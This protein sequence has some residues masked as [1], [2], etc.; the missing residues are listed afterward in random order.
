MKGIKNVA[1]ILLIAALALA[2]AL[3]SACSASP[4]S[5]QP[6]LGT[7]SV[8]SG[9]DTPQGGAKIALLTL[10][11]YM[12]QPIGQE[13]WDA[14]TRFAGE[15]GITKGLYKTEENEAAPTLDLAVKGGAKLVIVLGQE[16][17]ALMEQAQR[18][19]PDVYFV[20][21][22]ADENVDLYS[23]GLGVRF[24][25]EQAGWLA[26][27]A[28][29]CNGLHTM[30][31]FESEDLTDQRYALGFLL[32][33][34]AAVN[35]GNAPGALA[36]FP[37]N[38]PGEATL[39]WQERLTQLLH[40]GVQ[41]VFANVPTAQVEILALAQEYDVPVIVTDGGGADDIAALTTTTK[42][43]YAVLLLVLE[44]WKLNNLPW[45]ELRV[46]GIAG[47]AIALEIPAE[48][49]NFTQA[50]YETAIER[51]TDDKVEELMENLLQPDE[52]G[53]LPS[54]QSLGLQ[55]VWVSG[56]FSYTSPASSSSQEQAPPPES[57]APPQDA[58]PDVQSTPPSSIDQSSSATES[59]SSL[60]PSEGGES[61][62]G[63]AG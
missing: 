31:F 60:P 34:E 57:N 10:P 24:A 17:Y 46:A 25:S 21:L 54:P 11:V 52:D 59:S 4:A 13:T 61:P 32:G 36:M 27:Y 42:N 28:A 18:E 26:G 19:Y 53:M 35:S 29:A 55:H 22:D 63:G 45:G 30:A 58:A 56:P 1:A 16:L 12:E 8:L 33:A 48:F 7:H 51:F 5:S 3:F 6:T 14:I 38:F 50:D 49:E 44:G 15:E 62:P 9:A 39:P 23:N 40:G 37:V 20:L 43:P 41:A 2:L 47:D